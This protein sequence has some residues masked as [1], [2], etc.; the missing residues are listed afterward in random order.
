[1]RLYNGK[2]LPSPTVDQPSDEELQVESDDGCCQTTDGCYTEPD[3]DCEHGH[4]S[5]L[6]YLGYI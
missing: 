2:P 5:W 3:G 4:V 1:M 6:I